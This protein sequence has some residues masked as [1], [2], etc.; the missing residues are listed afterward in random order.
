MASPTPTPPKNV[1]I[2]THL[3]KELWHKILFWALFPAPPPII[4]EWRT[5]EP[6]FITLL[7]AN[8]NAYPLDVALEEYNKTLK[9]WKTIESVAELKEFKGLGAKAVLTFRHFRL[10]YPTE[11]HLQSLEFFSLIHSQSTLWN[12]LE[13]ITIDMTN[14]RYVVSRQPLGDIRMLIAAS[15][16]PKVLIIVATE[17]APFRAVGYLNKCLG[18]EGKLL[19]IHEFS[20]TLLVW[21]WERE[22]FNN[23]VCDS[24]VIIREDQDPIVPTVVTHLVR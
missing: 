11:K 14:L 9:A 7:R 21:S 5:E 10:I 3:P 13:T 18:F 1:S 6:G 22:D 23:L 2:F 8:N 4:P 12:H 24:K 15:R 20:R 17:A 19:R 16:N